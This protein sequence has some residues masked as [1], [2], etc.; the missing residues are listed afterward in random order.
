M[1]TLDTLMKQGTQTASFYMDAACESIDFKFGKGFAKAHPE[2]LAAF[3]QTAA[4]DFMATTQH[5]QLESI[6]DT[7]KEM[8]IN[9]G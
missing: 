4:L 8:E 1:A 2:L 5:Q 6:A 7:L 3:M 9:R